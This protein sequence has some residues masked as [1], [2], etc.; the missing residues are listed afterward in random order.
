MFML[1]CVNMKYEFKCVYA[2]VGVRMF[3]CSC[4]YLVKCESVYVCILRMCVH[5]CVCL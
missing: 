3:M 1:V 5:A 2:C 4:M